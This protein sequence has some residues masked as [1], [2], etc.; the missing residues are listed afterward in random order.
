VTLATVAAAS[1]EEIVPFDVFRAHKPVFRALTQARSKF[2]GKR[3]AIV[4]GDERVLTYDDIVRA[5]LALGHALKAGTHAGESVG[6]MLPSGAGAVIAFFAVSAY[7][8]VPA[9][10]N[11]TAGAAA[12][13]AALQMAQVKR[14]VTAHRFVELGKFEGLIA[15]LKDA[16]QIIYLEDVRD[17]LTIVD[18][19]FA[20]VGQFLPFAVT[21]RPA[22]A[23]PAVIL[24]T[25]GTEGD[26]KG[27]ALSH[28]NILSNVE[29]VRSH[30]ALYD[31]D[32]LFNPL[33]TFHCFG[34]TVGVLMP[35]LLGIKVVLHPT[36]LQPREIVRRIKDSGATIL[37]S[38]DTFISQYA[39]AGDQG[40]LNSLRLAVCGAERLRDET[41]ALLRKKYS[42]ELLEGYGVTE[43]A[44]VIAANQPGA[45]RAGTVGR[46]VQGME[47]RLEPVEGISNA[48]R[49]YVRGPNVMLGY[50][51]PD[52]PGVIVPP[53]GGWHDTG[54]VVTIDEEGFIAIKG[55]LKRFAKI[56]GETVSLAVAGL[57]PCRRDNSGRPQRRADCAR[58]HLPRCKAHRSHRLGPQPRRPRTRRSAAYHPGGVRARARHRQDGLYKGS[59]DGEGEHGVRGVGGKRDVSSLALFIRFQSDFNLPL[60]EPYVARTIFL[61]RGDCRCVRRHSVARLCRISDPPKYRR[62]PAQRAQFY[63]GAMDRYPHGNRRRSQHGGTDDR[64]SSR[65]SSS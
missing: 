54:D 32:I 27:V 58:H 25:S 59:E 6:I 26:P 10:L 33:P 48:G 13:K 45:N 5:S 18:K 24:F 15:E 9:M 8:R 20:A 36:P 14:I 56:G 41:R 46:L 3:A 50:I 22:H 12:I 4:D 16:A 23:T 31:S 60:E 49:L 21:A 47:S 64:R 42:I 30:I 1:G 63:H 62:A 17:H 28:L 34:L 43:A 11:F 52:N 44:P 37:L 40:D 61:Y 29:Q 55:R 7:G 53:A 19:A 65:R 39:R 57:Q 38:T 35:L 2:G 51:K